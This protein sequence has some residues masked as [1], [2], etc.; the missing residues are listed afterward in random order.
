MYQHDSFRTPL[1]NPLALARATN[2]ETGVTLFIHDI[3]VVTEFVA[4]VK[5]Q[6]SVLSRSGFKLSRVRE[7]LYFERIKQFWFSFFSFMA[8]DC[9]FHLHQTRG[10]VL[11]WQTFM[12]MTIISTAL[13]LF[14]KQEFMK[15]TFMVLRQH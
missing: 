14:L 6:V 15:L 9:T 8:I 10:K 7:E 1:C 4:S 2:T 13:V 12:Q 11:H 3:K 5:A